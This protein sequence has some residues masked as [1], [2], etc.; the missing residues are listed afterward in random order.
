VLYPRR[1]TPTPLLVW[2]FRNR[3]FVNPRAPIGSTSLRWV[4]G[5]I[6]GETCFPS[7]RSF[8]TQLQIPIVDLGVELPRLPFLYERLEKPGPGHWRGLA[9]FPF[10]R[11]IAVA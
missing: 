2:S 10:L 7:Y 5:S 11:G 3:S 9:P 1:P 6:G 8:H 4:W